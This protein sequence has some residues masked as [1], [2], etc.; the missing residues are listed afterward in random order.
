MLIQQKL[1]PPSLLFSD[2]AGHLPI[3]VKGN[4][5]NFSKFSNVLLRFAEADL[6]D[7]QTHV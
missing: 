7:W 5:K 3:E 2:F 1:T 4:L 6:E